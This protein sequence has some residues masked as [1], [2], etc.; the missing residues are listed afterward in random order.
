MSEWKK[1]GLNDGKGKLSDDAQ[2]LETVYH[3]VHARICRRILEDEKMRAGIIGDESILKTSRIAVVWTSANYWHNG[4]IYGSVR[5]GF[6]WRKLVRNRNIYWVEA[7]EYSNPAYRL[8][9][10]E[11]DLSNDK[12]LQAYDPET[13][14]GPLR[15]I[16]ETWY[17]NG[18][19]TS[20]FMIDQDIPLSKVAS[21][22]FVGHAKCRES[23]SCNEEKVGHQSTGGQ[24]M[25]FILGNGIHGLDIHPAT[26]P[27]YRL[28][29][30]H[31]CP[32]AASRPALSVDKE[33]DGQVPSAPVSR[34]P[35]GYL[36]FRLRATH[37]MRAEAL[38]SPRRRLPRLRLRTA[39]QCNSRRRRG[40]SRPAPA[41]FGKRSASIR[42]AA[43]RR[44]MPYHRN[45]P[46][47]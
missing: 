20:E 5:F 8:L 12:R 9:I 40:G 46:G 6:K 2:E 1:Y 10:T 17:W 44:R 29:N 27:D 39:A 11:R 47:G 24:V 26:L 38:R 25:S 19:Y 35:E 36:D 23:R 14:D 42:T 31:A 16:D 4:S 13:D 33:P 7:R 3:I 15:K 34:A 28:G 21:F 45:A 22:D 32:D 30:P 41:F 43:G 18:R 37:A